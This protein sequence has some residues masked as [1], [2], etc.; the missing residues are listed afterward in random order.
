[1]INPSLD[2]RPVMHPRSFNPGV[3]PS[4]DQSISIWSSLLFASSS[5]PSSAAMDLML[6]Y[7]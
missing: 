7:I 6:C 1:M 2:P 5:H 4:I 3:Y